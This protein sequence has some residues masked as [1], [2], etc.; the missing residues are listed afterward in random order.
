MEATPQA[1][2]ILFNEAM[3]IERTQHLGVGHYERSNNRLPSDIQ[4][5]PMGAL[6]KHLKRYLIF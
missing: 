5:Y 1:M 2:E 4:F 3:L 6:A